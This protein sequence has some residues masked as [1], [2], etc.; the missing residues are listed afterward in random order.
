[1]RIIAFPKNGVAYTDS[2]YKSVEN[3]NIPVIQG[4]FS[5]GW[6]FENIMPGDWIH[7]HWPSFEYTIRGGKIRALKGFLRFVFILLL[8][9]SK[10]GRIAWTAHNLFPHDRNIIPVIDVIARKTVIKLSDVIFTHGHEALRIVAERFPS[11]RDKLVQ[12]PHGHWIG[13]Y[14]SVWTKIESRKMIGTDPSAYVYL[15]IGGC[16]PYKNLDGLV[17]CFKRITGNK[18]LIVAGVFQDPIYQKHIF[19]LAESDPRIQ[20]LP[21]FIPNDQMAK[22]LN[23]CDAIVVPYREIL[24]SGTAMLALSYGRPVLS[25]DMGFLRE[26]IPNNVGL[27]FSP[28]DQDGLYSA[29]QKMPSLHFSEEEIRLHSAKFTFDDAANIFVNALKGMD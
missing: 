4:I 21:G 12:I 3:K 19:D 5:G 13:V 11:S 29:L 27:L 8:V 23:A 26:T 7:L 24:T 2:F 17:E 18:A 15:F 10:R 6:I 1:M 14:P 25:V 9:R 20:I 22:F 28:T 16:K